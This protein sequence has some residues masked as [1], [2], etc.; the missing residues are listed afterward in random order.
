[1]KNHKTVSSLLDTF[2]AIWNSQPCEVCN[3]HCL[4]SI[5]QLLLLLVSS[6]RAFLSPCKLYKVPSSVP[7]SSSKKLW[8]ECVNE[9][10]TSWFRFVVGSSYYISVCYSFCLRI[11]GLKALQCRQRKV[12]VGNISAIITTITRQKISA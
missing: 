2:I 11:R 4:N 8:L 3:R 1:M 12:E 9:V 7:S 10:K 6:L 5:S